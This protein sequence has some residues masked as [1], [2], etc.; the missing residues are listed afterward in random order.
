MAGKL[1]EANEYRFGPKND[2]S[3]VVANTQ[4][5][6]EKALKAQEAAAIQTVDALTTPPEAQ[7]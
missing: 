1:I 2:W 4:P 6:R 7:A 3:I 5:L